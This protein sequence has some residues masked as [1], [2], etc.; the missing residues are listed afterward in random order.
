[1]IRAIALFE[2]RYQLRRPLLWLMFGVFFMVTFVIAVNENFV[3]DVALFNVHRNAPIEIV[4]SLGQ[5]SIFGLLFTAVFVAGAILRD[6]DGNTHELFFSRP[7]RRLDYLL[8]RFLGA[9]LI[10]VLA[11]TG[12][13]AGLLVGQL[14]WWLLDPQQLGP[15][16]ASPYLWALLVL[17]LP[18]FFFSSAVFFS[19]A[20]LTRSMLKTFLGVVGL[21]GAYTISTGMLDDFDNRY[22]AALVDPFGLGALQEATRYWTAVE[23]NSM[24]PELSGALLHNRLL[25]LGMAVAVLS[26]AL[27]RFRYA[28]RSRPGKGPAAPDA[29]SIGPGPAAGSLA[30][31]PLDRTFTNAAAFRQFLHQTRVEVTAMF[32][33]V[34]FLILMAFAVLNLVG[35]SSYTEAMFGVPA[36]PVTH[37]MIGLLGDSFLFILLIIMFYSGELVWRERAVKLSQV[38]DAMPVP[39]WVYLSAK[40]AALTLVVVAFMLAGVLTAIGIQIGHGYHHFELALY[41]KGFVIVVLPLLLISILASFLQVASGKKFVGYL[42]M[43]VYIVIRK[44]SGYLSFEHYLFRYA[45]TPGVRYSDMN[46]YGHYVE[47]LVWFNLYWAFAAAVLTSLAVLLWVRGTETGLRTRLRI[48]AQRFRGPVRLALPAAVVGFLAT[49]AWIF[50]NTNVVNE[51]M[52]NPEGDARQAD[53]EKKFRRYKDVDLPR[54]T[55]VR[56]NVDI[57]PRERRIEARGRYLCVNRNQAPLADLHLIVPREVTVNSLEF[58]AHREILHDAEHGYRIYRLEQPL[59]PGEEM[60]LR[61]DLTVEPRGF[62]NRG[63]NASIVGNGTYFNNQQYFPSFGYDERAQPVDRNLRRKYDLPPV[64]P[65]A[66]V[67]DLFARRNTYF[68]I[69]ADWIRFETTVSTSTDQI[70]VA[71]GSL[72]KEWTEGGRRYFHYRVEAP[73]LHKYCYISADYTVARDRW[74]DVAIEVYYH[75]PHRFNVDRMIDSV[76]KSLAYYSESFG[77]YQHRQLRIVET[78]RY[79]IS[80]QSLPTTVAYSEASGFIAKVDDEDAIDYPFYIIAHEVAHQWWAHQVVSG[81]V[82]GATLMSETLA[83]YSA[84]MVMEREY[85]KEKMRRF[86]KHELDTYLRGRSREMVEEVP[87]YRVGDQGYIRYNKGSVVMYALRDA[88]GEEPLNQALASYVEAVK[89]QSPPYTNSLE[90]LD[91]LRRAVPAEKQGLITDFFETVTLFDNRVEKASFDRR[92][93]GKYVVTVEAGVRKLRA[94]GQGVETEIPLDDWIDVGVFGEKRVDGRTEETVLW[95]EKRHVTSPEVSFELVVDE[96]PVRAGIDPYNKLIDRDSEDNVKRVGEGSRGRVRS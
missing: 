96:R 88:I 58:P 3:P 24:V 27:S 61:F 66:A 93:D 16:T 23:C 12:T 91:F 36:Y 14:K 39:N 30:L 77:P 75:Q 92:G 7:M 20:S 37:L 2:L 34:P 9:F 28:A 11:Y 40:L 59:A 32:Q 47:P 52:T 74:R 84:L 76:K 65:A 67:D 35:S 25:W 94:D 26:F 18:N 60:E 10:S 63:G 81:N 51:Y 29:V 56:V 22:L 95:L 15:F 33:G 82:Q 54:I 17:V 8:G 62:V 89:F 48:A 73:M 50:Y 5:M 72:Q 45:E 31:P 21:F 19:L 1:M 43:V 70:A 86:L 68:A 41:A 85:G 83:Q 4:K 46:G 69:D 64:E 13:V 49:G 79:G 55:D 44:A 90:F 42:L 71:P 6:F 78:P 80:V 87:L 53:Y 57:Y 38:V